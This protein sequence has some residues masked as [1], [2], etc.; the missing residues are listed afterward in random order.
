MV[1]PSYA[2]GKKKSPYI[3]GFSAG[4]QR[5]RPRRPGRACGAAAAAAAAAGV[6]AAQRGVI[7][8]TDGKIRLRMQILRSFHSLLYVLHEC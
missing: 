7:W 5:D 4:R 6:G 3:G 1:T 2:Q 8:I